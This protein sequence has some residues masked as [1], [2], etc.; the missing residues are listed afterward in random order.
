MLLVLGFCDRAI[1]G[2]RSRECVRL[3]DSVEKVAGQVF[4][5]VVELALDAEHG[6]EP[7]GFLKAVAVPM[8]SQGA[9]FKSGT[10]MRSLDGLRTRSVM[11]YET[12]QAAADAADRA[13]QGGPPGA[14]ITFVS[15]EVFQ[16]MAQA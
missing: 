1:R 8:I 15:A 3:T 4:G 16:V 14:P 12:E 6:E 11:L 2:H 13:K 7:I 5:L 10:W 9:G